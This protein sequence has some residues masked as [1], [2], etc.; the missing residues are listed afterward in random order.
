MLNL[1]IGELDSPRITIP[2]LVYSIDVHV[3]ILAS[4]CRVNKRAKKIILYRLSP[5]DFRHTG[6]SDQEVCYGFF[7]AFKG[8]VQARR[9]GRVLFVGIL[10]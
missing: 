4:Q 5:F 8:K 3:G 2:V 7:F 10:K 9:F 1:L 6:G